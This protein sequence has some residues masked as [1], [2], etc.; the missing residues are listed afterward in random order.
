MFRKLKE[1]K[2]YRVKAFLSLLSVHSFI[3]G[4]ALM[5]FPSEF[6]EL[7]GF[8]I[9]SERFFQV[10]AGVFHIIMS[11]CYILPVYR[12]DQNKGLINFT[13]IV[14]FCATIFL[15]IYFVFVDSILLVLLSGFGDGIMALVLFLLYRSFKN[16]Q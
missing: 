5:F 2:M 10:Q 12:Y 4:L 16:Q 15:L 9:I 13:I 3:V 6:M 1:N 14:K 8:G 11:I 7:L